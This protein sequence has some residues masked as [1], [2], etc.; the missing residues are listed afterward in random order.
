MEESPFWEANMSSATQENSPH[1]MEPESWL[2]HSQQPATC[3]YSEPDRSSPCPHPIY[4]RSILILS[5]RLRL[6]LPSSLLPSGFATKALYA[7]RLSPIRATCPAHLTL[8]FLTFLHGVYWGNFTP[9]GIS[10]SI[11]SSTILQQCRSKWDIWGYYR[12]V[13]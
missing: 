10:Y 7:P 12:S 1:F 3:P 11:F 5:S 6:G 2:T 13:D 9:Q 4:L 8:Y